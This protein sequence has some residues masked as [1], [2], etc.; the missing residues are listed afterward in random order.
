ML[1]IRFVLAVVRFEMAKSTKGTTKSKAKSKPE[2][3]IWT[4]DE[5]ELLL[6]VTQEY[7]VGQT[8]ENVDWESCH[9]KHSSTLLGVKV[10]KH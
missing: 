10:R 8:A 5:V 4:D 2:S 1:R 9:S 3:F 7:K 6:K